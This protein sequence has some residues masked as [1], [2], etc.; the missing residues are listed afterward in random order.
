MRLAWVPRGGQAGRRSLAQPWIRGEKAESSTIRGGLVL[1]P[2]EGIPLGCRGSIKLKVA[3]VW[4]SKCGRKRT[5]CGC[6]SWG[7]DSKGSK[8][9]K[10]RSLEE[11]T[12]QF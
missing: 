5:G 9:T 8:L 12:V 2:Q 3:E 11:V 10:R 1:G 4:Q 6:S 7:Q